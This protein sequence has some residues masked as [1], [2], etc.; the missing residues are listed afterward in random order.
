MAKK[1]NWNKG[2]LSAIEES[3]R[4]VVVS[5]AAGSGKTAVLVE[6]TIRQLSDEQA[7]ISADRLLAVTFTNA[8]VA[9]LRDKLTDAL[10]EKIRE[11]PDSE[12]LAKQQSKLQMAK[13]MT[14]NAFSLE[15]IRNHCHIIG[16]QSNL[17]ILEEN[18][19][20]IIE[21]EAATRALDEF[22]RDEP[23]KMR[24]YIGKL[25][26]YDSQIISTGLKLYH[27]LRSIP[28]C[29]R[30]ME[31]A[32]KRLR[33][34]D[35]TDE[36]LRYISDIAIADLKR[37]KMSLE[38]ATV[39]AS[40]MKFTHGVDKTIAE[41]IYHI[42][43][44]IKLL[45]DGDWDKAVAEILG[46]KMANNKKKPLK[47][48]LMCY[49]D[50]AQITSD[51]MYLE[52]I[53][54]FRDEFKKLYNDN[55]AA[56]V[57]TDRLTH[58]NQNALCADISEFLYSF[59]RRISE[60]VWEEKQRRGGVDFADVELLTVELL[61]RVENARIVRT[62]LCREIVSSGEYAAILIDEYQDTNNLQDLIFKAISDTEDIELPG[63]NMFIVGDVK[64]AIYGFR[65]SNPRL[66]M[67][68]RRLAEKQENRKI[69]TEVVLE[70]NYRSRKEVLE[71]SNFVFSQIMSPK[72][73]EVSYS[74][75]ELLQYGEGYDDKDMPTE[76]LLFEDAEHIAVAKKIRTMLDEGTPVFD[77]G[78]YRPCVPSD[79]CVLSRSKGQ[80][81][82]YAGAFEAL[83]LHISCSEING[84]LK[85]REIA[86]IVN[87]LKVIDNPMNDMA[88]LSVMLSPLF[89]FSDDEVA[90]LKTASKWNNR[91][92]Q[93]L[94]EASKFEYSLDEGIIDKCRR[95]VDMVKLLRYY[96][97]TM[98][99]EQLIRQLYNETDFYVLSCTFTS[100]LQSQ[101]NLRL[102]IDFAKQYDSN[103]AGGLTG[104]L[105]YFDN[106][107]EYDKDFSQA[108]VVTEQTNAVN[109]MTMH[110]SKGLEFPFV[111]LCNLKKG[112]KEDSSDKLLL[113]SDL[114]IGLT[115]T[116]ND[117]LTKYQNSS[118][119]VISK[120]MH[121]AMLSEELRLL[122]VAM[123]RAKE[124][125]FVMIPS[126]PLEFTAVK[127]PS[128][129]SATAAGQYI[130][131]NAAAMAGCMLDW[132]LC[133]MAFHEKGQDLLDS[134]GCTNPILNPTGE[135]SI[136]ILHTDSA[137][138]LP[139]ANKTTDAN[140]DKAMVSELSKI[141]STPQTKP[142]GGYAKISVSEVVHGNEQ[143]PTFFPQIP[144]LSHELDSFSTAKRG[145]LTHRFMELCD[146]ANATK[147]VET[148]L[149]RL[150]SLGH[151]TEKETKGIYLGAI[152]KF[153]SGS[154]GKRVMSSTEIL[155]EK[156]FM[157]KL[158]D[159]SLP[160]EKFGEIV[161]SEGMIQ[162]IADC[163]FE[164][165]DGYV[166]VDYKTDKVN[167]LDELVARYSL[168]LD[169]YKAAF[170]LLLS[171]PIKSCII[172]SFYLSEGI[173]IE[174]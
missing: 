163:I 84:Y 145:T 139:T 115:V 14:I 164:E 88:M 23:Q 136:R 160:E 123:T 172:Y 25:C 49:D 17:S 70:N 111:F 97:S 8:A 69:L 119:I 73:G 68:A 102:L 64:Q 121:Y 57:C 174:L 144:K 126:N 28:F 125:L 153:F 116:D 12:W 86:L 10:A 157:L 150:V 19:V 11:N 104:F 132:I 26:S 161:S 72:I 166:L 52:N 20:S 101:A 54:A 98:S 147:S 40:K 152:K 83:G 7:G 41:D 99:I 37:A 154:L 120:K 2:Q 148:E 21:Q 77:S 6:R 151:F 103:C 128:M 66:F 92:Y 96:A 71:F 36:D 162:G 141:L 133:A 146:F 75:G 89:M 16:L 142:I 90:I 35:S 118:H 82:L 114:G 34:D 55:V 32:I 13:I 74:G 129:L 124:Q 112:F 87:L 158:S 173:D 81:F 155:R 31:N 93:L 62:E 140:A 171:K 165:A 29:E 94:L 5:A 30:Y 58:I 169:L 78:K 51:T 59:V 18:D 106:V 47:S 4:G 1:T 91:L 135:C 131:E 3:G 79:F 167:N 168:Q 143:T 159:L 33:N 46:Y 65:Q 60:L 45:S 100:A 76:F 156:Q 15:F 53:S 138:F 50:E 63:K 27:F 127:L 9:Q 61:L 56:I 44:V 108:A 105:R 42:D 85:S 113:D 38:K 110:K 130:S 39:I 24:E 80:N 122:Y 149:A 109:V 22:Y 170:E 117:I 134:I 95:T 67:N 43:T 48:E 107:I 137:K